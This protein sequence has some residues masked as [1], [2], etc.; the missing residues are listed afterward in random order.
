MGHS[1]NNAEWLVCFFEMNVAKNAAEPTEA[2]MF[3]S[4]KSSVVSFNKP[5]SA[6][7]MIASEH[8]AEIILKVFVGVNVTLIGPLRSA[9][10]QN[11]AKKQT[12]ATKNTFIAMGKKAFL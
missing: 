4:P 6:L 8:M 3:K 2:N 5:L 11:A 12:A 1:A 7:T 9:R 10:K